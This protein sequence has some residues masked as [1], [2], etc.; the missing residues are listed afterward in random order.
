MFVLYWNRVRGDSGCSTC[1]GIVSMRELGGPSSPPALQPTS[2]SFFFTGCPT[3]SPIN[4]CKLIIIS[5]AYLLKLTYFTLANPVSGHFQQC[6]IIHWMPVI[7]QLW[8]NLI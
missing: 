6:T 2:I 7:T 8:M 1:F 3:A 5:S 4:L